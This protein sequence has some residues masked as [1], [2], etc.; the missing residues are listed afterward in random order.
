MQ[1]AVGAQQAQIA[2]HPIPK[3]RKHAAPKM[4]ELANVQHPQVAAKKV[5][6]QV[7][8]FTHNL[9]GYI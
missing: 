4:A 3:G 6:I 5:T 8:Q 9:L 2:R 7:N 1:T